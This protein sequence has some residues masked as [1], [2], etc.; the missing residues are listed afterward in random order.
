[1]A[2]VARLAAIEVSTRRD[3]IDEELRNLKNLVSQ[4]TDQT[5]LEGIE[6][7]IVDLETEQAALHSEPK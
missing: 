3:D 5:T 6:A 4:L 7:L 1:M 2:G